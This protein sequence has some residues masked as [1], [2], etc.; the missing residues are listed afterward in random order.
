M[1]YPCTHLIQERGSCTNPCR[2]GGVRVGKTIDCTSNFLVSS[3]LRI[4]HS[5]EVSGP[6]QT[7]P[8]PG[9]INSGRNNSDLSEIS[10]TQNS[11]VGNFYEQKFLTHQKWTPKPSRSVLKRSEFIIPGSSNIFWRHLSY[12][13]LFLSP[14]GVVKKFEARNP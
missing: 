10:E 11:C 5:F 2:V 9:K 14:D 12:Q 8:N 3:L 13:N 1:W 6:F 4:F 7:H